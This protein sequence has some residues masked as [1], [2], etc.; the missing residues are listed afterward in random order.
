MDFADIPRVVRVNEIDCKSRKY[1]Y[2]IDNKYIVEEYYLDGDEWIT[3]ING[4]KEFRDHEIT[5]LQY[6]DGSYNNENELWTNYDYT[7]MEM[8]SMLGAI[9]EDSNITFSI[10]NSVFN[11][12]NNKLVDED[13]IEFKDKG[14]SIKDLINGVFKV[15]NYIPKL[16]EIKN[17]NELNESSIYKR[18]IHII[19]NYDNNFEKYHR[20]HLNNASSNLEII[21]VCKSETDFYTNNTKKYQSYLYAE[22]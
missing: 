19:Q 5:V 8:F 1:D 2:M 4:K 13:G 10:D 9:P 20:I 11:V 18:N 17:I 22:L 3:C 15:S 21:S 6:L 7:Y 12:V 16:E 14:Y